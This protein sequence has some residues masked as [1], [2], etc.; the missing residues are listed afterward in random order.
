MGLQ[1]DSDALDAE[2]WEAFVNDPVLENACDD[3]SASQSQQ[4]EE[5]VVA[6]SLIPVPEAACASP[7]R[8]LPNS[9]STSTSSI[10]SFSMTTRA[11]PPNQLALVE[12]S[13]NSDGPE[14]WSEAS[15]QE[16]EQERP[17]LPSGL[18]RFHDFERPHFIFETV[19]SD[20]D[21]AHRYPLDGLELKGETTRDLAEQLESLLVKAVR[22]EDF[23]AVLASNRHFI[24]LDKDGEYITS[25]A[26][27]ERETIFILNQMYLKER[28]AEFFTK[29][30]DGYATLATVPERT[31]LLM[32]EEKKVALGVLGPVVSLSLVYGIGTEPLNPIL[33][34]Y[35]YNDSDLRSIRE[36]NDDNVQPLCQSLCELSRNFVAMHR[37]LA[38]DMLHN[39]IVGPERVAHPYFRAFREGLFMACPDSRNMPQFAQAFIGGPEKFVGPTYACYIRSYRSLRLEYAIELEQNTLTTLENLL[40]SLP[41]MNTVNF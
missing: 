34:M 37:A 1:N 9:R 16:W 23:S 26:G 40:A 41:A 10:S 8:S 35:C 21:K 19:A 39:C 27:I 25:G 22:E 38:W 5:G 28:E 17:A 3:G 24:L 2:G 14:L 20:L 36:D 7:I 29:K 15:I 33:L 11:P 30:V 31:A 6:Q 4:E 13:N 18:E 12:E 32:S